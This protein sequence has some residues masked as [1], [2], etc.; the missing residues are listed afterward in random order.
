MTIANFIEWVEAHPNPVFIYMIIIPAAAFIAT[1]FF[2]DTANRSPGKYLFS[3]LI[4]LTC[5]PG[6]LAVV[7][8]GY[9]LLMQRTNILDVNILVYFLPI[10]SMALTIAVINRVTKMRDV[11]GFRRLSGFMLMIGVSFVLVFML[12]RM[13]FGVVF[14][15]TLQS[16]LLLF[17][18]IFVILKIG[19]E[20]LSS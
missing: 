2:E 12:Q 8:T 9:A 19:W 15:G 14:F 17:V 20:R 7:L 18:V 4:Y 11:P 10:I 6:V 1:M 16:L 13:F 5:I 3:A